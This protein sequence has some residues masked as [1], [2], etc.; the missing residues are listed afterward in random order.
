MTRLT[1]RRLEAITE[2]LTSKLAGELDS[3]DLTREDY[4]AAQAWAD[5]QLEKR[6]SP[7]K[8]Q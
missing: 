8:L 6:H 1:K 4:E 2:A 5:E 3:A 7:R